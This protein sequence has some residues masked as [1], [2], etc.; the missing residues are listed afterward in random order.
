MTVSKR[1]GAPVGP[2][3]VAAF[4]IAGIALGLVFSGQ[5]HPVA[6]IWLLI[7]GYLAYM[8]RGVIGQAQRFRPVEP[9]NV[10]LFTLIANLVLMGLGIGAFG[11]YISGGGALSWVPLLIFIAGMI[12]LR[13]WRNG[14]TARIY[15][16]REPALILL[17]RGDYRQLIREL[18]DDATT[19][20]GHPDKLAMVALAYIEQ[21]KLNK[22]EKLLMQ[23][24]QLAP[25]FAS[26]N[27]AIGSLRR[28]QARYDEAAAAIQKAIMFE[29]NVNSSYYLGLCQYLADQRDAALGTLTAIIDDEG[30]SRQGQVYGAYMLGQIAADAGNDEAAQFWYGRMAEHAPRVLPAL[31]DEWRRHKQT[32]YG[33]TLKANVRHMEQIIARRPLAET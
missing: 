13:Q 15:A 25:E 12:A 4:V 2:F 18:E 32:P 17:Q 11:W 3:E 14:V 9:P 5:M 27:G 1:T 7:L 10:W 26:V 19:G 29:E 31:N 6:L 8:A 23:A 22:A 30:L 20:E 16:W 33:D 24:R 21:N 28:H